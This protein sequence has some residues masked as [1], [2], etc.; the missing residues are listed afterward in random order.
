[1]S[2]LNEKP[3][4]RRQ[5]SAIDLPLTWQ[6]VA[7]QRLTNH[8]YVAT[9]MSQPALVYRK[10]RK[11]NFV[12]GA[13]LD[14]N[15]TKANQPTDASKQINWGKKAKSNIIIYK[16][17]KNRRPKTIRQTLRE[18]PPKNVYWFLLCMFFAFLLI[19]IFLTCY[20]FFYYE[21]NL[22]L[23]KVARLAV[24]MSNCVSRSFESIGN[25]DAHQLEQM[26]AEIEKKEQEDEE[27]TPRIII[28]KS[29]D[30]ETHRYA[31]TAIC[32]SCSSPHIQELILNSNQTC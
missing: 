21:T 31:V 17:M 9:Q 16:K 27:S 28:S 26:H 29:M 18:V 13:I 3:Q 32:P 12:R 30:F 22:N 11:S 10:Q 15:E 14:W 1:M 7:F 20:G 2:E 5:Y 23:T 4:E 6:F 24:T 19:G 8:I 25:N